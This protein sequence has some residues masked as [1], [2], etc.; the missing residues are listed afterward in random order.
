MDEGASDEGSLSEKGQHYYDESSALLSATKAPQSHPSINGTVDDT[1]QPE[2]PFK[3]QEMMRNIILLSS[4]FLILF[5]SYNS[6][7]NLLTSLL[8]GNLGNE[9]LATL[10]LSVAIFVFAAPSVVARIG[11]KWSMFWGAAMY[12]LYMGSCIHVIPAVVLVFSVV[13]GAG[14]AVLWVAFGAYLIK[15]SSKENYGRNSGLFWSIFQFS[16]VFGNLGAY[17]VFNHLG[18]LALF[19]GFTIVGGLG[20]LSLLFLG[21]PHHV[22]PDPNI[23]SRLSVALSP[24]QQAFEALKLAITPHMVL[25]A[26]MM[27]FSG[28]EL[29]FWTGAFP[30]ILDK[31]T[32]GLVLTFA[33]IGEVIGGLG[34]GWL[35]DHFG[36]SSAVILGSVVY[37]T[38][39]GLSVI[40][41]NYEAPDPAPSW[42]DASFVAYIA[43][44]CFGIGDSTFNTQMYS[45]L[46]HKYSG[47]LSVHSFSVFQLW[48]NL[49]SAA[50][51]YLQIWQPLT[52]G[53]LTQIWLQ[54]AILILGVIGYLAVEQTI[55]KHRHGLDPP[56]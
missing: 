35:S 48:Q 14:S 47:V 29:S 32:I 45:L 43:S 27:F 19:I 55:K 21:K 56:E 17:F 41:R 49:G 18:N 28:Y 31:K 54:A 51:Y 53:P 50:G 20:T 38:G 37:A 52:H 5:L 11:E 36:R 39:M 16:N 13:I 46:G 2:A 15:C 44:F 22:G 40:L 1:A 6:L 7:Q 33:G 34:I 42:A 30:P 23:P 9:S 10:Y 3:S 8:P 12:V 26:P 4:A 24:L 25:L